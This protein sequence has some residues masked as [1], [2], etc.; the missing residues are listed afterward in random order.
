MPDE[1][2]PPAAMPRVASPPAGRPAVALPAVALSEVALPDVGP[3]AR[4]VLRLVARAEGTAAEVAG[5]R[6]FASGYDVPFDYGRS[7]PPTPRP[8]SRMTLDEVDAHQTAMRPCG[9][10]AVGRYQFLQG[11]LQEL[12]RRH[13]LDGGRRFDGPLQDALA[14][15]K[16]RERGYDA[17]AAGDATADAV[18]DGLAAEWASL[19]MA[20][21]LSRYSFRGRRQPVRVTRAELKAT[22]DAACRLDFGPPPAP[23]GTG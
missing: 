1:G 4:R 7:G 23:A 9:S 3:G 21:G 2:R 6:G 14:R 22:L 18:M 20:D 5:R 19:P 12:R 15:A 8:L 11:T 17:Y 13:G 16:L 10:T